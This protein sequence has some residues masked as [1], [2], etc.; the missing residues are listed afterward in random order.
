MLYRCFD[1]ARYLDARCYQ[2]PEEVEGHPSRSFPSTQAWLLLRS[3]TRRRGAWSEDYSFRSRRRRFAVLLLDAT[4]ERGYGYRPIPFRHSEFH[5]GHQH[6]ADCNDRE[7]VSDFPIRI[8]LGSPD[9][10]ISIP[11]LKGLVAQL[12]RDNAAA[13][14][15]L[16]A[17]LLID[18]MTEL[19]TL[20]STFCGKLK[21]S[22][23]ADGADKTFVHRNQALYKTFKKSIW[24]T[25]PDLR[26]HE[27]PERYYRPAI[28]DADLE[29]P[30][31]TGYAKEMVV[32]GLYDVRKVI[33]Q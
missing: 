7:S 14:E 29:D 3:P 23:Y 25:A 31:F 9:L 11:T 18:P 6:L 20:V 19:L 24:V 27:Y 21:D 1:E 13:L 30:E 2:L 8:N 16:P 15:A 28:D 17:P 22:V 4:M 5:F 33:K 26:P 12:L 32:W 10:L